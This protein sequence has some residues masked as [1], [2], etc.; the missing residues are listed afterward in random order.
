M[1][2]LLLVSGVIGELSIASPTLPKLAFAVFASP[3]FASSIVT[4]SVCMVCEP[5]FTVKPVFRFTNT[6]NLGDRNGVRTP[7]QWNGGWN[8]GF[9]SADPER[10]YAP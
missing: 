1:V 6:I 9:S 7:V 4:S 5:A 10:L 2:Q 3:N 8:G